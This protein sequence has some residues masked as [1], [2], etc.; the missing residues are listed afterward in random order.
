MIFR[1]VG[2]ETFHV[3]GRTDV[4][5]VKQTDTTKLIDGLRDFPKRPN[6]WKH[7]SIVPIPGHLLRGAS[8]NKQ[9]LLSLTA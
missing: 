7:K 5:R 1:R 9:R 3:E 8:E 4:P 2:A 6:K